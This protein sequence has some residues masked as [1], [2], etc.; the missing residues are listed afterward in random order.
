MMDIKTMG[1][2]WLLLFRLAAWLF[3]AK[4]RQKTNALRLYPKSMKDT[5][6]IVVFALHNIL[7]GVPYKPSV[8]QKQI[9]SPNVYRLT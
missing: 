4:R 2:I 1:Q 6:S 3:A 8:P 9:Y 7:H 5:F